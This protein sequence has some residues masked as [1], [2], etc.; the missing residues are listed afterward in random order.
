MREIKFKAWDK[1]KNTMMSPQDFSKHHTIDGNGKITACALYKEMFKN[2]SNS[3]VLLQYT[4]LKD[5][6][7]T[8]IYA[9]DIVKHIPY[10]HAA[11]EEEM[12]EI[13][14][15]QYNDG[16]CYVDEKHLGWFAFNS[17]DNRRRETLIDIHN[18]CEVIGNKF[19][20]PELLNK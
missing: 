13:R 5:K 11:E 6:N 7:G 9:S 16:E 4:G 1:T 17:K 3:I 12:V 18:N 10:H 20:S 19:E 2:V 8:E 15:G 14:F